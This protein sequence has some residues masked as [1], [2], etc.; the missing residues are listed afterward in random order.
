M[1]LPKGHPSHER[2]SISQDYRYPPP[3]AHHFSPGPS[4]SFHHAYTASL[5]AAGHPEQHQLSQPPMLQQR[6]V[7]TRLPPR[8]DDRSGY[9]Q[10]DSLAVIPGNVDPMDQQR[11]DAFKKQALTTNP[12]FY[13]PNFAVMSS[14]AAENNHLPPAPPKECPPNLV[15]G[16]AVAMDAAP[17][18][19]SH[20]VSNMDMASSTSSP[21]TCTS[22]Q[23]PNNPEAAV[24]RTTA[25]DPAA[26]KDAVIAGSVTK[27][28]TE[29]EKSLMLR[30]KYAPK[31]NSLIQTLL[32]KGGPPPD[33]LS[34]DQFTDDANDVRVIAVKPIEP[35]QVYGPLK[36]SV[37][38]LDCLHNVQAWEL[39][40]D[41]MVAAYM[42]PAPRKEWMGFVRNARYPEECNLDA[43]Q[44]YGRIYFTVIKRVEPGTELRVF[45][46]DTYREN[47]GFMYDLSALNYNKDTDS[48]SCT[49]CN[50]KT[51]NSK[52]MVRHY[53]VTHP[54]DGLQEEK[55]VPLKVAERLK[56]LN[57]QCK[58]PPQYDEEDD[59]EEEEETKE[60]DAKVAE[61]NSEG[62]APKTSVQGVASMTNVQR[63]KSNHN[64]KRK[65]QDDGD[66]QRF[67][68]PTCGKNFPTHGR[69]VVHE[70]FH[71]NND[72][73]DNDT[74]NETDDDDDSVT[75]YIDHGN[76]IQ[77][78]ICGFTFK[79]IDKFKVHKKK[80]KTHRYMCDQCGNLYTRKTYMYRH[81]RENHGA[82]HVRAR[83]T[84]NVFMQ[85]E[86]TSAKAPQGRAGLLTSDDESTKNMPNRCKIC[87]YVTISNH[88]LREHLIQHQNR[89]YG[90]E[91]CGR[92]YMSR[93]KLYD[94]LRRKHGATKIHYLTPQRR[95]RIMKY[96]KEMTVQVLRC[97]ECGFSCR[98]RKSLEV[99]KQSHKLVRKVVRKVSTPVDLTDAETCEIC[100]FKTRDEEFFTEHINKHVAFPFGCKKCGNTYTTKKSLLRHHHEKH[101]EQ[102]LDNRDLDQSLG[103]KARLVH[104]KHKDACPECAFYTPHK[105][106]LNKHIARHKEFP[107]GCI[108][109]GNVYTR[110]S[111]LRRHQ[112]SKH[113]HLFTGGFEGPEKK[114]IGGLLR[115]MTSPEELQIQGD[116]CPHCGF[117]TPDKNFLTDH[118]ILHLTHPCGCRICGNVY[119][120][121]KFVMRHMQEKHPEAYREDVDVALTKGDQDSASDS[122]GERD[123]SLDDDLSS[124][125]G[126]HDGWELEGGVNDD[127]GRDDEMDGEG[128]I[129]EDEREEKMEDE[130]EDEEMEGEDYSDES[131]ASDFDDDEEASI[132]NEGDP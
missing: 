60:D 66:S 63:H 70:S 75:E 109:C 57:A 112:R 61:K 51:V 24:E 72:V 119:T 129:D 128:G 110:N 87:H 131:D 111:T 39:C 78:P 21:S 43:G 105:S 84:V 15:I 65:M 19:N 40:L 115:K 5:I 99:H 120:Q 74:E 64:A 30:K 93:G 56:L 41:G 67:I 126:K 101:E 71:T 14:V 31:P 26:P 49:M 48:F 25:T 18:E 4:P 34:Y 68:C 94:H 89:P 113:I 91:K 16:S 50:V 107:Y 42:A 38:T 121:K 90:C 88:M 76:G 8:I 52:S 17:R 23:P 12:Y 103:L 73:K 9:Q 82:V 44:V 28:L 54:D 59:E 22:L 122:G 77:C 2:P 35:G 83:R 118:V 98:D 114:E 86:N 81:Q 55:S 104:S 11:P 102:D 106:V 33:E 69:L 46:S 45:Y 1:E 20:M 37:K 32:K 3:S 130:E 79:D 117:R 85:G 10:P 36:G 97:G 53:K 127:Y 124:E 13:H 58:L 27:E 96:L 47:C 125:S 132:G 7:V 95:Q 108:E 29:E 100:G 62:E 92:V 6:D 80:H 123:G 116:A